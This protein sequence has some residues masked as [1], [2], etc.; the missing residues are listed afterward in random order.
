MHYTS[1]NVLYPGWLYFKSF[2]SEFRLVDKIKNLVAARAGGAVCKKK[3][4]G[5]KPAAEC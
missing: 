2:G 5:E 4:N 1:A 3:E